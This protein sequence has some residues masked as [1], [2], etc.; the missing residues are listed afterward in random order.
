MLGVPPGPTTTVLGCPVVEGPTPPPWEAAVDTGYFVADHDRALVRQD[1]A[2]LYV[3]HGTEVVIDVP[4]EQRPAYDFLV[5]SIA[6]RLLLLQRGRFTLHAT[7]VES[8]DGRAVAI[9][10]PGTVGKTTTAVALA[11]RGWSFVCDDIVGATAGP[12][13][14]TAHPYPRP[15]H[16]SDELASRLGVDPA[17]GRELPGASKRVYAVASDTTPRPLAAIVRVDLSDHDH[18]AVRRQPLLEALPMLAVLSD[19]AELCQLPPYRAP[20]LSWLSELLTHVP[21]I[22]VVRPQH[23]AS[24]DAVADAVEAAIRDL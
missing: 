17:I 8:P 14:V 3:A 23:G 19:S 18:V 9:T 20:F 2:S 11:Q 5:Y 22:E 10:G 15:L 12:D 7:L 1:D 13:G 21:V 4:P 6:L 24:V 16:A